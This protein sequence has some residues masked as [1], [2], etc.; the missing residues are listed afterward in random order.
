MDFDCF[1]GEPAEVF[2]DLVRALGPEE[3]F[4]IL[5]VD[6]NKLFNGSLQFF[7]TAV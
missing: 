5:I 3:G 7:N 1:C 4:G 6:R 2:K